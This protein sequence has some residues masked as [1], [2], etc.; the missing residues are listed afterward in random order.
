MTLII[1]TDDNLAMAKAVLRKRHAEIRSAHLTEALAFGLGFGTHA[2]LRAGLAAEAGRP[3]AVADGDAERFARRLV[4]LGYDTVE[5][6]G[7]DDA[8][9][10]PTL[11]DLPFARFKRGDIGA[12][13]R[14]YDECRRKNRPMVMVIM[15]RRYAELQWDCITLSGEQNDHLSRAAGD[16][17]GRLLFDRFQALAKG[18][19]GKPYFTGKA[20]TGWVERLLPE[21][22]ERLA[23]DYFKLLYLP[24]REPPVPHRQAA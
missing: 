23:E 24:L 12:N 20:F 9:T 1:L 10:S 11:P 2:A 15:G 21:T 7:F 5:T 16:A 8:L 14:H 4:E 17:L 22:A 18:A 3:P 6:A 13:N 19:P